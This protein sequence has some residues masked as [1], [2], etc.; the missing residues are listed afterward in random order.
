MPAKRSQGSRMKADKNKTILGSGNL[1]II[2]KGKYADLDMSR[3][4]EGTASGPVKEYRISDL[5]EYMLNPGPVEIVKKLV[6]CEIHYPQPFSS[7]V[8]EKI[9][10]LLPQKLRGRM[11]I[12]VNRPEVL[13]SQYETETPILEDDS[14]ELHFK[15]IDELLRTYDPALKRLLTLDRSQISDVIG[16]SEN[17]GNGRSRLSL[18]GNTEE[19][20]NYMLNSISKR[21]GTVLEKAH[22][23][24]GLFE[25]GGFDFTSY[26]P[27]KF[28]RLI[29]FTQDGKSRYCVLSPYNKIYYWVEDTKMIHYMHLLEQSIQT[30]PKLKDSFNQ[31]I[32]G[33]AK[34]LILFFNKQLEIEYSNA[35]PPAI[36]KEVFDICDMRAVERDA[37][38]NSLS[39]FQ[40]GIAFNY[41]PQSNSIKDR[42]CT[43]ISVM[44]DIR[45]LDPIKENLPQ[46]YSEINKRAFLSEAGKFYLL[47][48]IRGYRNA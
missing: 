3:I 6:G 11:N 23:S 31:C 46:L 14:L 4:V 7:K 25:M 36:Y 2:S 27:D 42:L 44:H 45:A 10:E 5:A 39:N 8:K 33:E 34:P 9:R 37:V 22:I 17:T 20:I 35:H 19:K 18:Q 16:I 30:N 13:I 38:M 21:V 40:V 26:N 24:D 48:S 29:R 15:K 47:D 43:A 12:T 32:N 1:W 41:V 28:H